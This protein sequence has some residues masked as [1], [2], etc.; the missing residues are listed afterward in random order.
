VNAKRIWQGWKRFAHR[1]AVIQSAILLT[2]LYWV[3]VMP[4]G[5]LRRRARG[6]GRP[7]WKTRSASGPVTI[8]EARRQF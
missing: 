6:G 4:I 2:V 8:E 7:E 3:V 5:L 1:A